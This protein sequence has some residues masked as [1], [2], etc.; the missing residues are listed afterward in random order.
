MSSPHDPSDAGA[1]AGAR[2]P[3]VEPTEEIDVPPGGR[4]ADYQQPLRTTAANA[5][6]AVGRGVGR[7]TVGG[8]R[9]T[10]RAGRFTSHTYH[11]YT[12]SGGA[13]ESGLARVTELHATHAA[14]DA[15][16]MVALAGTVFLNPQTVQA[17]DEVA[18]FLLLTMIPFTLIAPFLGPLLD[19]IPF[20]R[21]WA[22]GTTM[23]LRGFLCWVMAEALTNH[24]NWLFP[25]ALTYLVASKCYTV[26][27]AAAVP[28]V[29]PPDTTLVKA[30]SKVSVAGIIGG[31]VGGALAGALMFGGAPWALRAAFVVF[32]VGTIQAI[33]LPARIDSSEGE[34]DP[35]D[36]APIPIESRAG[37][38]G[39]ERH[40]HPPEDHALTVDSL[41]IFGRVRRRVR[42]I[43]WPVR[44]AMWSTG[45]TRLLTG[46]LI[47]FMAFLA[48]EH[49]I[50]GLHAGIVLGL[51]GVGIGVGNACGSILGNVLREHRPERVAMITLLVAMVTC[52]AT[53]IWYGLLL[54]V[55]IG[56]VQGL[57]SQL[58][59]LCLDA[60]IQREIDE[61]VRTSV[62]GWSETTL[63]MLWVVGGALGI[64]LPLNPHIGFP[65][66]A[67][68]LLGCVILAAR[69]RWVGRPAR[70]LPKAA[71]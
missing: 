45:G 19:R 21:R 36:T 64:I 38:A 43:P 13:G 12:H 5:T 57:S 51:V 42:A 20:G 31:T 9:L 65:V 11:G 71:S 49:P 34:L 8:A 66:A 16:M 24:S 41:G 55:V 4:P 28:R 7:A 40:I 26:V 50:D 48:R 60:L 22:I 70:P 62:F 67:A 2:R 56:L 23:A 33:R 54:I 1:D 18:S 59:K 61:R 35:E 6:R 39:S 68:A 32:V 25:A 10:A 63:Q 53:G 27:R 29:L 52:A 44:H 15:A 3:R 47:L 37:R 46:F 58:A 69:S 17:R 14:G 30:N